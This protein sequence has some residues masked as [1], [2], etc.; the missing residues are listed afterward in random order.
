MIA[1][2]TGHD[3]WLVIFSVGFILIG[4]FVPKFY[5]ATGITYM[6][7]QSKQIPTWIGRTAFIGAGLLMLIPEIIHLFST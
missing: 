4:I 3:Y 6:S 7:S 1:G 5:G 2:M